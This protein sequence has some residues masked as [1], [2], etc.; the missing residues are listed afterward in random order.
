[1]SPASY[2]AAPPRVVCPTLAHDPARRKIHNAGHFPR[3]AC[4]HRQAP[5]R[6]LVRHANGRPK[7]ATIMKLGAQ[8]R[9]DHD[10]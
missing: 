5:Q 4:T 10:L 3:V 9:A 6:G 8:N 1:M 7:I 2:R